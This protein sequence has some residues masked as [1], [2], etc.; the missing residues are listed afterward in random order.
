MA[1]SQLF[2]PITVGDL[3]LQHRVVHAPL[4]RLR[5][6]NQHVINRLVPEYYAQRASEP[7]TLLISEATLVAAEAGG[8][9]NV[10]GIWSDEQIAEWKSVSGR[11]GVYIGVRH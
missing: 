6:T 8:M 4:T 11:L 7:G 5:V 2:Q 1:N 10:P 9:T 3:R